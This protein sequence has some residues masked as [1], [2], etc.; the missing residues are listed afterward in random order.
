MAAGPLGFVGGG[1]KAQLTASQDSTPLPPLPAVLAALQVW[2]GCVLPLA[3][4]LTVE[5]RAYRSYR[6]QR[7]RFMLIIERRQ[8]RDE[9]RYLTRAAAARRRD[10]ATAA[11]LSP[12]DL[13]S[14][15]SGPDSPESAEEAR[16]VGA[17]AAALAD[18]FPAPPGLLLASDWQYEWGYRAYLTLRQL[19]GWHALPVAAI[20]LL[21][22]ASHVL[23]YG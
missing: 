7:L 1:S 12:G 15:S 18:T 19:A 17:Q 14:S 20:L 6:T 8:L 23:A 22:Y 13:S 11:G 2:L 9:S 21:V 16:T 4:A 10:Q 3:L 5:G